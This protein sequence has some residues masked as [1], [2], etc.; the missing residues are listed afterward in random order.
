MIH[1]VLCFLESFDL[2]F[3]TVLTS[4]KQVDSFENDI[5]P[6]VCYTCNRCI[7]LENAEEKK[8]RK[9]FHCIIEKL[10]KISISFS[11]FYLFMMMS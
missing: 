9:R 8:N 7:A 4:L 3:S 11:L 1:L 5:I 10:K 6:M 2:I